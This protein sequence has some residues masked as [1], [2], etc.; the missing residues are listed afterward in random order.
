MIAWNPFPY[1]GYVDANNHFI[2]SLLGGLFI[3]LF[4]SDS[5]WIIRLPSLLAFPLYFW[6]IF[7]LRNFFEHKINFYWLLI[8]LTCSAF[9]IE[10]FGLARGYG[11]SMALLVFALLQTLLCFRDGKI[12]HLIAALFAWVFAIYANLTLIP[13]AL[14]GL[15]YLA[16][17]LWKEDRKRWIG[18]IGVALIPIGYAVKYSFHLKEVGKL[19]LGGQEGIVDTTLH[20]LTPY[21]WNVENAVID[22]ALVAVTLFLAFTVIW[23]FSRRKNIFDSRMVFSLFLI[24]GVCNILGQN[25]LLGINFPQDRAAIYLVIFFFGGLCFAI[26]YWKNKWLAYP[27][28]LLTLGFFGFHLNLNKSIFFYYEHFDIELLTKIPSQVNGI[29]PITGGR[30]WRMD[31]E[32]TREENLP[33]NVLQA[34]RNPSDTLQDYLVQRTENRAGLS[35]LYHPIHQDMISGLVLFERN[36][37]LPRTK[38]VEKNFH[39]NQAQEFNILYEQPIDKPMFFRCSGTLEDMDMF[40]K[41]SLIF[42]A[43]DT[44]NQER[45]Y[46]QAIAM[47]E[48]CAIQENGELRFD[49]SVA[50]PTYSKANKSTFYIWNADKTKLKGEIKLE[51]YSIL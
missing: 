8:A 7:G 38:T 13:F 1:Q 41:V 33:L 11:I 40:K 19:Y 18:A 26:D 30:F 42:S 51:V 2:N 6:S 23:N 29:P 36:H 15:V 4:Q 47:V 16:V 35:N 9:L 25:W 50:V 44:I 20:S 12:N 46:Y 10:Y 39:L 45:I 24:L 48:N 5:M 3:R 34:V 37:F 28:I 43:D 49:F 17:Y 21:L 31:N 14:A 27:F 32:L 22:I